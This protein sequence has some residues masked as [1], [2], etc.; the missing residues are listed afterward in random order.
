MQKFID[1]AN[2][3]F[4]RKGYSSIEQDYLFIG[5]NSLSLNKMQAGMPRDTE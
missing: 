5:T 2:N 4:M 1:E 3:C